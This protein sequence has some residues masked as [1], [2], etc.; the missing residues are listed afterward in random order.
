ML[1]FNEQQVLN[2]TKQLIERSKS[3][4]NFEQQMFDYFRNLYDI[5]NFKGPFPDNFMYKIEMLTKNDDEYKF[6][7]KSLYLNPQIFC[8]QLQL[9]I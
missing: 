5:S 4:K 6:L 8:K 2:T 9:R 1:N 7:Q 3:F